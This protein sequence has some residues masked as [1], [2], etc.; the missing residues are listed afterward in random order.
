MADGVSNGEGITT[1]AVLDG[2]TVKTWV[3]VGVELGMVV[4]VKLGD[5]I[6]VTV[7]VVERSKVGVK[8]G[9]KIVPVAVGVTLSVGVPVSARAVGEKH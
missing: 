5:G 9:L 6:C 7:L 4:L 3:G 2:V 1:V 8:V